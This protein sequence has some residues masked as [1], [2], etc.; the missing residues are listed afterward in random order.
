M[1]ARTFPSWV[2]EPPTCEACGREHTVGAV[3]AGGAEPLAGGPSEVSALTC[4][5]GH[6][7]PAC[8]PAPSQMGVESRPAWLRVGVDQRGTLDLWVAEGFGIPRAAADSFADL[9]RWLRVLLPHERRLRQA[10]STWSLV[11]ELGLLYA[12]RPKRTLEPER[13]AVVLGVLHEPRA[14][15]GCGTMVPKG[16]TMVITPP[17]ASF[18][19]E[20]EVPKGDFP[21]VCEACVRAARDVA[22]ELDEASLERDVEQGGRSPERP[23]LTL[24]RG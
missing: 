6:W 4:G 2:V 5:W 1:A 12:P 13:A 15:Y 19:W 20:A 8:G 7:C 11:R 17:R 9:L 21:P 14:C 23:R 10:L 18:A 24:V 16:A 22:P 3:M